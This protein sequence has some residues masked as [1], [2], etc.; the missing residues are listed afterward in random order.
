MSKRL[1]Q[2]QMDLDAW[3]AAFTNGVRRTGPGS[4]SI[5]LPAPLRKAA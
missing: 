1:P 4:Y 5:T 2:R 3:D